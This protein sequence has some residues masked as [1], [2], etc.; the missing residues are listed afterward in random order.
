MG[1]ETDVPVAPLMDELLG[2]DT[3]PGAAS[4]VSAGGTEVITLAHPF[5][6]SS[7]TGITL[8]NDG[9]S[10]NGSAEISHQVSIGQEVAITDNVQFNAVTSSAFLIGARTFTESGVDGNWAI[11]GSL[12]MTSDLSVTGDATIEGTLTAQEFHTEFVSASILY[13]SGSTRFGDTQEDTHYFTGSMY[14]TGSWGINGSNDITKI[15]N[16]V[17]LA[18]SSTT[19]LATEN[20][21]KTYMDVTV[22][23]TDSRLQYLRK[24]YVKISTTLV[25]NSTAS[26]SAVTASVPAAVP[27]LEALT[28]T[29]EHDFLFFING[30]YMEHDALEIQQAASSFYLKVDIDSIGYELESD[31]EILAWGKFDS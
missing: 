20:A 29:T 9:E 8:T 10:Y 3:F 12:S 5:T 18:E 27:G 23:N 15:T 4:Q 31:D 30:Q 11:T 14:V 6:L 24:Q 2:G 21:I 19:S 17:T 28:S 22:A 26:F 7:G 16:D 13:T 1:M 25:G